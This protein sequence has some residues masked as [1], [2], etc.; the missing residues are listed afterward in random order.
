VC[1]IPR[2]RENNYVQLHYLF[3]YLFGRTYSS[4]ERVEGPEDFFV[5]K[6]MCTSIPKLYHTRR[7]N[8][9]Q[10]TSIKF[11]QVWSVDWACWSV[12]SLTCDKIKKR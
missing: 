12:V 9:G 8:A 11:N 4:L 1:A 3:I 2:K 10:H 6:K 7:E 5:R